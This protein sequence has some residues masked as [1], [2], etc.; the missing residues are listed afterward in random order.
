[1]D[2]L[3]SSFCILTDG[4]LC[5]PAVQIAGL[6]RRLEFYIIRNI[7]R[8]TPGAGVCDREYYAFCALWS[9]VSVDMAQDA[10]SGLVYGRR[11]LLQPAY[12]TDSKD[13]QKR[14]FSIG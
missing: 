13:I 6:Q 4:G 10:D 11:V 8:D 3:V 2:L 14:I 5:Y 12:R 1:M 7:F 9:I